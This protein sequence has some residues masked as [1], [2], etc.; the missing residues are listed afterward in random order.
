[1]EMQAERE[2]AAAWFRTL[3][4]RIVAAFEALEDAGPGVQAPVGSNCA[5]RIARKAAAG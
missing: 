2:Q 1:M 4:D 5:R 3:R